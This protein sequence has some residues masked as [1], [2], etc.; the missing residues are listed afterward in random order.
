MHVSFQSLSLFALY[1]GV[2]FMQ[3]DFKKDT[4][5][6]HPAVKQKGLIS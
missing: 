5:F 1:F 3:V 4:N 2:F 6:F